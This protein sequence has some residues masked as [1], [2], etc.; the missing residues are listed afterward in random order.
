MMPGILSGHKDA[1]VSWARFRPLEGG[2]GLLKVQVF[3]LQSSIHLSSVDV[4][5]FLLPFSSQVF[6][7]MPLS[8]GVPL[9]DSTVSI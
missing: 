6:P 7:R 8:R 4:L 9:P 1:A 3:L 5:H 2:V